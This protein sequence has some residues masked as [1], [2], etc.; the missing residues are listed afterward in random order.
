MPTVIFFF[1]KEDNGGILSLRI[2]INTSK[3]KKK[4]PKADRH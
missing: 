2:S 1:L 3:V 4:N